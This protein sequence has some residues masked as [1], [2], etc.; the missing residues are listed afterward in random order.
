MAKQ[1]DFSLAEKMKLVS[2]TWCDSS[3]RSEEERCFYIDRRSRLSK[4]DLVRD[5]ERGGNR[6][7]KRNSEGKERMLGMLCFCVSN[8]NFRPRCACFR[9]ALEAKASDLLVL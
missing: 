5:F 4:K 1:V 7:R 9:A 3:V 2:F 6:S 8:R